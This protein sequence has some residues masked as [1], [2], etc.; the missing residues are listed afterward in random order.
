MWQT[1]IL[2][3]HWKHQ[4][5]M[6]YDEWSAESQEEAAGYSIDH[7]RDDVSLVRVE[8]VGPTMAAFGSMLVRR[9]H[10]LIR[11]EHVADWIKMRM[12]DDDDA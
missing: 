9:F 10:L 4:G 7:R 2:G 1:A 6:Y 3:M 11:C 12:S 8:L 5:R